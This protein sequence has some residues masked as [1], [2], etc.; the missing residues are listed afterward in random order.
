MT[1]GSAPLPAAP[2]AADGRAG[3]AGPAAA[4]PAAEVRFSLSARLLVLTVGFVMLAEVLI[5]APS[6]AQFRVDYL[7]DKLDQAHLV[8]TA[9]E[10][11]GGTI[12]PTL[13]DRLLDRADMLGMTLV[14]EGHPPLTLAPR[15]PPRIPTVYDL[16]DQSDWDRI[17]EA[18]AV[19]LRS[20]DPV[21]AVVDA[22]RDDPT[23]TI[24]A[25]LEEE[26]LREEM[27]DYAVR[28]LALSVFISMTTAA[29]VYFAMQWLAVRPLRRITE[30][31]I[32]FRAAPEDQTRV[33]A[34]TARRDEVGVAERALAEMQAQLREAL[35]QRERLAAVGVA[36]TK[37]SHDLKNVLATAMLESDRLTASPDPET[38]R[39]TDGIVRA[40]DRAVA[41]SK[42]TLTFAQEGLPTVRRRRQP[43]A[44]VLHE[45]TR[46][47]APL[48]PGCR[49]AVAADEG[50]HA[51]IDRDLL[52]RAL[53]N[54]VRNAAE[55]GATAVRIAWRADLAPALAVSDDGPGLPP[56]ARDN[57]FV[58][59]AGS[60]KPGGSG[61]GL[62]IA[63]ESLR[64]QGGDVWLESTGPAGT[65]FILRLPA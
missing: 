3:G 16:R 12:D 19:L 31:M 49:I 8:L 34:P 4:R 52:Q 14:R 45:V 20:G 46:T 13:R 61:L 50:L 35:A 23:V 5:F 65:T 38:R 41:M 24:E 21:F 47:L 43:L 17:A 39:I 36:V 11:A 10:A 33:I 9:L 54:L 26:P 15:I 57:L 2:A 58:P 64:A 48:W 32:A 56:R 42:S 60:A 59:F 63:R 22:D 18:F 27:H 51:A 28:V 1:D 62:P 30:A 6:V 44:P 29:L 25:V 53:E 7:R 37:V 55:A 40:I